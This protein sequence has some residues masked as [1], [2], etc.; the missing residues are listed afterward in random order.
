M[1]KKYNH[2]PE[3]LKQLQKVETGILKC[4]DDICEKHHFE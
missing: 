4:F 2:R 3:V 1:H